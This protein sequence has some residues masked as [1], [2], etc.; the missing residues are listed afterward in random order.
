VAKSTPFIGPILSANSNSIQERK[1]ALAQA[2]VDY[3]STQIQNLVPTQDVM[4]GGQYISVTHK[5][6]LTMIDGTVCS[7]LTSTLSSQKCYVC[8]A[9]PMEMNKP[10]VSSICH[11]VSAQLQSIN[12]I[13]IIII[14]IIDMEGSRCYCIRI[15]S[16]NVACLDSIFLIPT[17]HFI[18]AGSKEMADLE[19]GP[20]ESPAKKTLNTGKVPQRDGLT[21]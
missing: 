15:W 4:E 1:A 18:Q 14:I 16:V 20:G 9:T 12:I 11:R 7:A 13:I 8:G 5:L 10:D 19:T 2:E 17:T 21:G 3:I 6:S